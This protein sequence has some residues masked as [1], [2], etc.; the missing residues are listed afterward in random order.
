MRMDMDGL[1]SVVESEGVEM[2]RGEG[3]VNSQQLL[4]H[5][6]AIMT[7][8]A[9]P[10]A[11]LVAS[12]MRMYAASGHNPLYLI[13]ILNGLPTDQI[14]RLLPRLLY[15]P[16]HQL[17][18]AFRKLLHS[19]P[20]AAI[21]P[22]ELLLALHLIP[23]EVRKRTPAQMALLTPAD[24]ARERR[25]DEEGLDKRV[26]AATKLCFDDPQSFPPE[27]LG[28]V[29]SQL[30]DHT[31]LPK[32]LMRTVMQSMLLH[33]SLR[34]FIVSNLL[35]KLIQRHIYLIPVL[36]TGFMAAANLLLPQSIPVLI[37]LPDQPF[38]QMM[39]TNKFEKMQ[40]QIVT[41]VQSFPMQVRRSI[42][43]IVAQ[44]QQEFMLQ[45]TAM[46]QQIFMQQTQQQTHAQEPAQQMQMSMRQV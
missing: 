5:C 10:T 1:V 32:L 25:E 3:V 26:I 24:I 18:L 44:R 41:F 46:Q 37:Q 22:A 33:T 12:V 2:K 39:Q 28:V 27:V 21:K 4:L 43:E 38:V 19:K 11:S 16:P 17:H 29:L 6:L 7:E 30:S 40:A 34:A 23:M 20:P 14:R 8:R 42:R 45:Q 13:S 15:L 9:A 31:P 36:W 35:L